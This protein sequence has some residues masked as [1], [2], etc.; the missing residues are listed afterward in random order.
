MIK[1]YNKIN[2]SELMI[3]I[4]VEVSKAQE[5]RVTVFLKASHCQG[6]L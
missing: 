5:V 2:E 1:S 4:S 3:M 6:R